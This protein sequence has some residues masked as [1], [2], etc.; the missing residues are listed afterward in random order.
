MLTREELDKIPKQNK[1]APHEGM[2]EKVLLSDASF[3][4]YGGNRG[5]GKSFAMMLDPVYDIDN[6]KFTGQFFRKNKDDI[7]LNGGLWDKAK[8]VYPL[9]GGEPKESAL[10]Y[11]FPSGAVLNFSH[12]ENESIKKIESRFKGL[13]I[14]YIAIDEID[15]I[16]FSTVKKLIESNRNSN[17]IRN[18]F[19]GSCNP[20][21]DT[22]L[23]KWIDWYVGEDG[24]IIPERDGVIRYFFLTGNTVD[25]VV[26]GNSKEEVYH[27]CK[28]MIDA[29]WS[30]KF[31]EYGMNKLDLIKDFVF[32]QGDLAENKELLESDPTYL[33]NIA[34]GSEADRQRNLAGNWNLSTID[35]EQMVSA[36][37]IEEFFT[38]A[39]QRTGQKRM[40]IDVALKG[41]DFCVI[42][43]WDGL[44]IIDVI[45]RGYIATT[46]DFKGFINM[47]IDKYDIQEDN[48]AYDS[49]GV[50]SVMSDY[51]RAYPVEANAKPL[52]NSESFQKLKDQIMW[53]FGS[54]MLDGK[55]SIDEN[56]LDKMFNCGKRGKMTLRE[57]IQHEMKA[58]RI[59]DSTGKTAM[60]P[61]RAKT[62]VSMK[63]IL[64]HSPDFLES[65]AY[66]IVFALKNKHKKKT[67]VKGLYNL[68]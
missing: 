32:I 41:G 6:P 18:R 64:G 59:A 16:Q 42:T 65:M 67:H 35:T 17:G 15:Q 58:L 40:S 55:I 45:A 53:T 37:E 56:L 1:L 4:I 9:V 24:Y 66:G 61:K 14:P 63:S 27:K 5:G 43:I 60:I 46:S 13:E 57:I 28:N 47:Y 54:Y 52:N 20:S 44:H 10:K 34:M 33:A 26:W 51:K 30:D 62:G 31:A 8:T 36:A 38:N 48:I 29:S 49:I 39:E 3:I 21:S 50:G 2:Q 12:L 22:W 19:H 23:R 68:Y 11:V 7:E 25:D